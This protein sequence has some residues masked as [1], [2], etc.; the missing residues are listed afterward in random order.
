[1]KFLTILGLLVS[2]FFFWNSRLGVCT[3]CINWN[4]TST[5]AIIVG[6]DG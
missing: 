2:F 6:E 3:S 1:M 4:L 5:C